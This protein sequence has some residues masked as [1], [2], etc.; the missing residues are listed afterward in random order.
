[1]EY[2]KDNYD[3]KFDL[4]IGTQNMQELGIILDF[5]TNMILIDKIKLPMCKIK[6]IEK[7]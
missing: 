3:P 1:M 5:S 7:T 4:I 2:D 6:R